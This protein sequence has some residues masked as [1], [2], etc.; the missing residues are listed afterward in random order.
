MEAQTS[1]LQA[2]D[3]LQKP[4]TPDRLLVAIQ[5][6]LPTMEKPSK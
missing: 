3:H 2:V 4:V 1:K 6:A 5:I